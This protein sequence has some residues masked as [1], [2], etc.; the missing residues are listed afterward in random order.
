M[1]SFY[2]VVC[3]VVCVWCALSTVVLVATDPHSAVA[4]DY[5]TALLSDKPVV[6]YRFEEAEG[7]IAVN[8]V[9]G[10]EEASVNGSYI[11]SLIHI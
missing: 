5:L 7:G 6:L 8:S 11:L 4:E 1:K 10:G 3:R 9:P 2:H